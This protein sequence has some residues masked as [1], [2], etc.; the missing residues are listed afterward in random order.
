ME[1]LHTPVLNLIVLAL[2]LEIDCLK[3]KLL[4]GE[5]SFSKFFFFFFLHALVYLI[6][7]ELLFG[8]FNSYHLKLI[9]RN[10]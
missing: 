9:V 3:L 1:G 10:N 2:L 6:V 4:A 7:L 8:G 5:L